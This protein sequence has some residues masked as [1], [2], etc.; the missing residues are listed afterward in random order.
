MATAPFSGIHGSVGEKRAHSRYT[1]WFPVTVETPAG[2]IWAVCRDASAGGIMISGSIALTVGDEVTVKFRT[3]HDE[4]DERHIQGRVVRV[5]PPEEDPVSE[6]P[7]NMA[8]EFGTPAPDLESR[9]KRASSMPPA[10]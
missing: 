5:E 1:L 9:L 3:T 10:M 8:I 6:W 7:Y 4:T 2:S